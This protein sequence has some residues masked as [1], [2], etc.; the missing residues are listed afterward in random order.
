[1]DQANKSKRSLLQKPW[2]I[3]SGI[4]VGVIIGLTDKSLAL[5]IGKFGDIFLNLLKMCVIPIMITAVSSALA[6]IIKNHAIKIH[7]FRIL[8]LFVIGLL[9]ASLIGILLGVITG[10]GLHL[11]QKVQQEIGNLLLQH[12][13]MH[14][15][16]ELA[17][18]GIIARLVPQNILSAIVNENNLAIIVF[19]ILFGIALGFVQSPAGE[20]T[21]HAL[22][23][24]YNAFL[25]IVRGI[26][27]L[28][29][30]GLC[31][32]FAKEIATIGWHIMVPLAELLLITFIGVVIL[33][34]AQLFVMMI[35]A[36]QSM[37]SIIKKLK[38]VYIIGAV[39]QSSFSALPFL[40]SSFE[41]KFNFDRNKVELFA[42]LGVCMHPQGSAF[43]FSLIAVFIA[44]LYGHHITWG[45]WLI[46]LLGSPLVGIAMGGVPAIAAFSMLSIMFTPLGLPL[47]TTI[48]LLI[49]ISQIAD[50]L[51]TMVN[52]N[53]NAMAVMYLIRRTGAITEDNAT[54][55]K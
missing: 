55:L 20:V 50:P 27:Y 45:Q 44:N 3:F 37:W 5:A 49:A 10:V 28:L 17:P 43:F 15:Q 35:V 32:I 29:P 47:Y 48:I 2:V 14:T 8:L 25:L 18:T 30:F 4:G 13:L 22:D 6:R 31:A 16:H 38:N 7:I 39:T 33:L 34:V 21:L 11:G 19:A 36:R 24:I 54:D 26:I 23:G 52:L 9:V 1:M 46:I 42:P 40:F 51:M 12:H 53:G 41:S